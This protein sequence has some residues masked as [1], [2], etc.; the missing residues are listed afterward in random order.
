MKRAL[1]ICL[2]ISAIAFFGWGCAKKTPFIPAQPTGT[3]AAVAPNVPGAQAST[4]NLTA[5][6]T[7]EI[8]SSI[9]ANAMPDDTILF[10]YSANVSQEQK[11]P[12]PMPD[13]TRTEYTTL[14]KTYTSFTGDETKIVQVSITDTRSLPVLTAFMDSYSPYQND[15]GYRKQFRH[16]DT[17]TA[18]LTYMNSPDGDERGFGS[19]TMMIHG[20]FLVQIQGNKGVTADE[21]QSVAASIHQ[22][23]LQ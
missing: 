17:V 19:V 4:G 12:V 1:T 6:V 3:S 23:A 15:S 14:Q 5:T 11:N 18:W 13:G 7:P 8:S 20:R 10:G 22:N 9:L 16:D 21:L 2:L